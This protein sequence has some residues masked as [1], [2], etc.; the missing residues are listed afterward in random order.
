MPNGE[1]GTG[2][3]QKKGAVALREKSRNATALICIQT[4]YSFFFS[5]SEEKKNQ[6]E[7]LYQKSWVFR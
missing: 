2:G 5:F 6:K 7:E 3:R 4:V 1:S